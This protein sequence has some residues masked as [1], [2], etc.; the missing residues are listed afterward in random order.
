MRFI[1]SYS[2]QKNKTK[3]RTMILRYLFVM[4][5]GVAAVFFVPEAYRVDEVVQGDTFGITEGDSY[6]V[7]NGEK[8]DLYLEGEY[9]FSVSAIFE[10][11]RDL[12]IYTEEELR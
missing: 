9:V 6:F 8:Y 11:A 5:I 1:T 2:A 4:A 3:K 10:E 12:P 7:K